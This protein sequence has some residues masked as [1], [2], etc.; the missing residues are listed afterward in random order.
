MRSSAK[1][2]GIFCVVLA[3]ALSMAFQS[4]TLAETIGSPLIQRDKSDTDAGQV[5]VYLGL[6]QPFTQSG[7]ASSWSFYDAEHNGFVVTPL[8]F[9]NTAPGQYT[10]TG[11]GTTR[12]SDAS[13]IQNYDFGLIAGSDAVVAGQYT[14]GFT[15]RAYTFDGTSLVAG[16]SNTGVISADAP[17]IGADIW[18]ATNVGTAGGGPVALSIGTVIG[19]GGIAFFVDNTPYS[20]GTTR[21]YSAQMTT[22][23]EPA[24]LGAFS[25]LAIALVARRRA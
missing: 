20:P 8:I 9:E 24:L 18:R 15:D 22:V 6:T 19:D 5:Y 13:G 4:T 1:S 2:L 17:A 3:I 10:V 11:V 16:S 7:Q 23:P 21:T 14:F 12:T 25:M